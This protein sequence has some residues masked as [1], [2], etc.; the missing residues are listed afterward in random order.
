MT[1]FKKSINIPTTVSTAAS[2]ANY[3]NGANPNRSNYNMLLLNGPLVS[4]NGQVSFI[5]SGYSSNISITSAANNSPTSYTIAGI[6]GGMRV[7]E[8]IV[9][10][11]ATTVYSNTLFDIV[12]NI[13]VVG[14]V[15][16]A[17][18]V[19]I[20]SGSSIAIV[21]QNANSLA[22]N[23]Q[24]N[25]LCN[26]FVN[27]VGAVG[28]GWA[29]GQLNVYGVGGNGFTGPLTNTSLTSATRNNNYVPIPI[30]GAAKGPYTAVQLSNGFNVQTTCPFGAVI[31]YLTT[32]AGVVPALVPVFI[33]V[34]QG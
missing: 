1:V 5:A 18:D 26:V 21:L 12:T 7:S 19:A 8:T 22:D 20:G 6:S 25:T 31:V 9:G 33:E 16:F 28:A 3:P 15:A 30:T 24:P 13:T 14:G 11:N 4:A 23:G 34:S 27:A 32:L 2:V 10:P 29:A 17:Q